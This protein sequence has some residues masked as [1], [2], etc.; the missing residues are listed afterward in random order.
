MVP[1]YDPTAGPVL[2]PE[3]WGKFVRWDSTRRKVLVEF[4]YSYLVEFDG[5][6][7]YVPLMPQGGG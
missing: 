5:D 4:E 1:E 2:T 3:G 6:E 7:C